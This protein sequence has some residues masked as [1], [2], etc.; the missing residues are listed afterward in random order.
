MRSA[1]GKGVV[2]LQRVEGASP[3]GAAT[4]NAEL[5]STVIEAA[6]AALCEAAASRE[7]FRS[8]EVLVKPNVFMPHAP[9]TTDPRVVAGVIS[10][11]LDAG[12]R[13][14]TVA[15]ESSISTRIG[16][17]SSTR[18]A[19]EHTGYQAM[20]AGFESPRVRLAE[21]RDEGTERIP[22]ER[23]LVLQEVD[24]PWLM[25][26]A[27]RVVNIPLLKF[28]LQTLITGAVKNTW[29]AAD[30]LQRMMNH[31]WTLAGA[32]LDV[33]HLRPPDLT[34]VD[35]LQPLTGDHSYG[36]PLDLRLLMAGTDSIALDSLGAYVLGWD[37]PLGIETV[38]LGAG[39]GL[40]EGRIA[41]LA[42]EGL[43]LGDLPR[44]QVPD[45]ARV[46]ADFPPLEVEWQCGRRVGPGCVAYV[47][48]GLRSLAKQTPEASGHWQIFIGEEP[49]LPDELG[50][51][52]LFIGACSLEGD[53]F[54][55]VQR[56]LYL[57]RRADDLTVIP[58]CPP[59]ALRTEMMRMVA[60]D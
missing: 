29:S 42:L 12:A 28:H 51:R 50:D 31:C 32:L 53:T 11:L 43:D 41:E 39:V 59:M 48:A 19:L 34:L 33:H 55:Q 1:A 35:A 9:A 4:H 36:D 20:M 47:T 18:E 56:R 3:R 38:R 6:V 25:A 27:D 16:R 23:G 60:L 15:E 2:H 14:V 17:G 24:Y 8:A 10:W 52:V 37:D 46:P 5:R 54:R 49:E 13:R 44:G 45:E 40:G 57:E 7:A 26:R 21:L 58:G 22:V 30:P